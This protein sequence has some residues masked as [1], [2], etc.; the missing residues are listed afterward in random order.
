MNAEITINI[1]SLVVAL[2][3]LMFS[4]ISFNHQQD[5]AELHARASVKPL[6]SI[7]SQ[8]YTNLKS[9]RLF[10]Y[11]VGPAIIKKAEF[12][13]DSKGP[14]TNRIVELFTLDIV[15][16]SFVNVVPNRAIPAEGN[17]VLIKQSLS[18]LQSQGYTQETALALLNQ[19]QQQ[20]KGIMVRIE[21]EDIYGNQMPVLEET[22]A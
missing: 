14:T 1:A 9:I 19:W 15:W 17:I 7:Q 20:K 22:L 3:A 18:H 21:Y 4:I 11:G 12:R 10:N 6:L 13:R 16:E 8:T 5:R 2:A